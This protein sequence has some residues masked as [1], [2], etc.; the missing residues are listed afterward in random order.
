MVGQKVG[1]QFPARCWDEFAS[2]GAGFFLDNVTADF[3]A[4]VTEDDD[5]ARL[6]FAVA[7]FD[8]AAGLDGVD[9][10]G[11]GAWPANAEVFEFLNQ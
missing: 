10:G 1:D 3:L 7:L 6:A 8:I 9:D 2:S 5:V 4:V 11:V